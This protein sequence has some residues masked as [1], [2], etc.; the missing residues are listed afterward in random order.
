MK[1]PKKRLIGNQEGLNLWKGH[2]DMASQFQQIRSELTG[3]KNELDALRKSN[4]DLKKSQDALKAS[5]RQIRIYTL[6]EWCDE[7]SS[8]SRDVGNTT[9]HGGDVIN[10]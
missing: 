1:D 4:V 9:V 6:N 3:M 8:T 7:W 5:Y 10:V 2:F